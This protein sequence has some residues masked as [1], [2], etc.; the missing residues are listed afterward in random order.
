MSILIPTRF[1]LFRKRLNHTSFNFLD[2]GSGSH[3]ATLTKQWFPLCNYH[4]IDLSR[5]WDYDEDD[6][7]AMDRFFEMDLTKLQFEDIPDDHYDV[8]MMSHVVEHLP[9]GDQVIE[10]LLPKLKKGGSVYIEFPGARSTKLPSRKGT[11][12]F[13]DDKSHCRLY[14]VDEVTAILSRNGCTIV[15]AGTRRDWDK[16]V[17]M[18]LRMISTRMKM[19]YVPGS[20]YWDLMGFAEYVYAEKS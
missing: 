15:S 4:G 6:I 1:R 5:D 20:V 7:R 12:N 16:I 17:A 13:Y 8:L 9:N 11:L 19:G 18:P 10:H 2:V 14:S 3:S